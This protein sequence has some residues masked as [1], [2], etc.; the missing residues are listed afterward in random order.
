MYASN[1]IAL[2]MISLPGLLA[3]SGDV[4]GVANLTVDF[5]VGP[6]HAYALSSEV[7]FTVLV[8]DADGRVVADFDT[9]AVEYRPS[10]ATDWKRLVLA[11]QTGLYVGKRVFTTS[12]GQDAR[13]VG[14]RPGG[15]P[16]MTVLHQP[17][18]SALHVMRWY[19]DQGN[20]RIEFE[21]APGDIKV[22]DAPVLKFW[23]W[24]KADAAGVRPA[25]T[26]LTAVVHCHEDNGMMADRSLTETSPGVYETNGWT[27]QT[28]GGASA[29][30]RFT[31]TDGT[32]IRA[33]APLVVAP[34]S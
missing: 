4:T 6:E 16:E 11:K 7:T 26:G 34:A 15:T 21:S 10:G 30:L 31:A 23:I 18:Q 8:E 28:A 12:G 27:F 17:T 25:V 5:N 2:L 19:T 1:R 22:G 9:L 3:C 33:K 32:T 24:G 20:Y 14:R 29:G 13:V